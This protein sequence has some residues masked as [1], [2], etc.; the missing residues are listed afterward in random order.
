MKVVAIG[1][2]ILIVG[3]CAAN[4]GPPQLVR[5]AKP[6]FGVEALH[7]GTIEVRGGCV[8]AGGGDRRPATVL[9]DPDVT[10]VDGNAAFRDGRSGVVVRFGQKFHAGAAI[11]RGN[12][13]GW[14]LRD[15]EKFFGVKLP[16]T[17]P[18]NDV[19]RLHDFI[20]AG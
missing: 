1:L 6:L 19:V 9:F 16:K 5:I 11:L 3:G 2:A 18:T 20:L 14:S 8:V 13:K 17:C 7:I 4:C 15:I 10:L 12:G